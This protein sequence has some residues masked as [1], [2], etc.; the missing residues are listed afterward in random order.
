MTRLCTLLTLAAALALNACASDNMAWHDTTYNPGSDPDAHGTLADN[1]Q[2]PGNQKSTM[3]SLTEAD[4]TFVITALSAGQY[5]V[6]AANKA[7]IRSSDQQ[8]KD[9]AQHMSEDHM[10]ANSQLT[11]L[12]SRKGITAPT[13]LTVDQI[14]QL[15]Q[16]D[17]LN[18]ADFDREYLSQQRQAHTEAVRIFEDASKTA[19]DKDVR[20]W[21]T[22]TLPTMEGH[23][24]MVKKMQEDKFGA[25]KVGMAQ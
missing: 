9:L 22:A 25:G 20:D 4:R 6:T 3:S 19:N 16:L 18:G 5:E 2:V 13:G 23:L 14:A 12:A 8:I 11:N 24:D 10:K 21:A 7:Q 15:S 1:P 17:K